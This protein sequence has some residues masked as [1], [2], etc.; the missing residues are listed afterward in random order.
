M[1]RCANKPNRL[2]HFIS[3]FLKQINT[4]FIAI[5]LRLKF[6]IQL[7]HAL[8]TIG[9]ISFIFLFGKMHLFLNGASTPPEATPQKNYK[10]QMIYS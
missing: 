1:R 2:N 9:S 7:L 4:F 3:K 6:L 10:N 5:E 8:L